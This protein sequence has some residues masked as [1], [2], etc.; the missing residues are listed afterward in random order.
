MTS[1]FDS[2]TAG[3]LHLKNRITMAALTR[4]RAERDGIPTPMHVK[5]YS[6]RAENGMVVT[7][8]TFF[9]DKNRA[10]LGQ[11]GIATDEQQEGWRAVADAVHEKGGTIVMQIMHGGRL[12]L[13]SINFEESGESASAIAPGVTLHGADGRQEVP[14]P[15]ELDADGIKRVID[16]F[17]AGARRAIDAG[18]DGVELHG[19]NGYLIHQFLSPAANHRTDEYGGSPQ[20]RA[21]FATEVA[22]AVAQE[23]GGDKV[24]LRISP[25]HN[26][27]GCR[28]EDEHDVRETYTA[29]LQ[30]ISDLKISY[31]SILH[32]DIDGELVAYLRETFG[33]FTIL[34][35][36]FGQITGY[37]EATHIVESGIADAV[38]VGREI[39][40]NPDLSYR[41]QNNLELNEIDSQ[42]FY[43][44][45]PKGYVDY[46]F[47]TKD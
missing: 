34:N 38:A 45:G 1:L 14:V 21:R 39:I 28:E 26:I 3:S 13:P 44:P 18:M 10:F 41:W 43:T 24:A 23:I 42:T 20:N 40:A 22:R 46:P 31:L 5:Y 17:V 9:A 8:G 15:Q 6:Q 37:Q 11:P 27:Q 30:G 32:H 33:G 16:G 29:L 47:V 36:G 2:A 19:A 12:T 7:E 25:M 35:S 4:S